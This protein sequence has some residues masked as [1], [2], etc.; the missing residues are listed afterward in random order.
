MSIVYLTINK[1]QY[2]DMVILLLLALAENLP[3]TGEADAAMGP[4]VR[5]LSIQ[6]WE[7]EVEG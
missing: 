5:G 3:E 4:E 7:V 2:Q 6:K 1:L